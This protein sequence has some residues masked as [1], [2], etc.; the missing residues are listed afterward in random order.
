MQCEP[1]I[2]APTKIPVLISPKIIPQTSP[3][4]I[5]GRPNNQ[6]VTEVPPKYGIA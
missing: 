6:K 3:P 5:K 2:A 1:C 4:I